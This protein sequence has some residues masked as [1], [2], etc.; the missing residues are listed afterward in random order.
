MGIKYFFKWYKDS[1]PDT[2]CGSHSAETVRP[3]DTKLLLLDLNGIIHTSCQKIYKYGS[4]EPKTLLKKSPVV[5]SGTCDQ[6]VFADVMLCINQLIA[7]V[8]PKEVVLCIDGVAPISKQ[9]QQRQ[10]RFLS[11]KTGGGFDP[12]CISPGTEFLFNMGTHL[13]LEIERK[14]EHEWLN[15][16]TVFF[17]DSLV[18]GE[19]EHKLYD[20]LRSNKSRI[21]EKRCTIVIGG[22]DADLIM[23]SM[24]VST[25]FLKDN[26]IY[27]LR[28]DLT[29]KKLLKYYLLDVNMLRDAIL[30]LGQKKPGYRTEEER[31]IVCDFVLLCFLVGNDFLPQIPLLNIYDGGLDLLLE[32]YFSNP[33][34]LTRFADNATRSNGDSGAEAAIKVNLGNFKDYFKFIGEVVS[35]QAISNYRS[36]SRNGHPNVLLDVILNEEMD[37]PTVAAHYYSAYSTKHGIR[38]TDAELYL[39]EIEWIFNYYAFGVSTVDWGVYYPNQYAPSPPDCL[40]AVAR[41][42]SMSESLSPTAERDTSDPRVNWEPPPPAH[43]RRVSSDR[44]RVSDPF[45]QLLCILPPHSANLLPDPL[46]SLLTTKLKQFHPES[47]EI[48]YDGKLNDWEGVPILPAL[49]YD[50]IQDLYAQHFPLISPKHLVRNLQSKQLMI[51]VLSSQ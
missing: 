48:D 3:D 2:V 11:K 30:K 46:K 47:I 20:F 7:K 44:N 29:S 25:I 28:E 35:V 8:D 15:V 36:L 24:L 1:F 34:Y 13:K 37:L 45:F 21:V 50:T 32:H 27:I 12:N 39:R 26:P 42:T 9:I 49:D 33:G 31:L 17:M 19:G 51:S 43:R 22:N 6:E 18:P 5:V 40:N 23:L 4:F 16:D 41:A 38:E 14:L 10:R